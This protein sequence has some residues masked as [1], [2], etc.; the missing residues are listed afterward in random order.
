MPKV[1]S[2][3]KMSDSGLLRF[4]GQGLSRFVEVGSYGLYVGV[5]IVNDDGYI[6]HFVLYSGIGRADGEA[7]RLGV[8]LEPAEKESIAPAL[9]AVASVADVEQYMLVGTEELVNDGK[10]RV[11]DLR[12]VRSTDVLNPVQNE[13]IGLAATQH[14]FLLVEADAVVDAVVGMKK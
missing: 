1:I 13:L 2:L 10:H 12:V 14:D 8:A 7:V 9:L 3:R 6:H 11:L 4:A 5:S